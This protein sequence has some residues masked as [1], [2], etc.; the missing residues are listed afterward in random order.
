MI[1]LPGQEAISALAAR[2]EDL[3]VEV[4]PDPDGVL[5]S[6][7]SGEGAVEVENAARPH[8]LADGTFFA[9]HYRTW[10]R[11]HAL[12]SETPLGVVSDLFAETAVRA[13]VGEKDRDPYA[14]LPEQG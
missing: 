10:D 9:L 6:V 11:T 2:I 12:K 4:T 14:D 3:G 7:P 1:H 5:L 8:E 13:A